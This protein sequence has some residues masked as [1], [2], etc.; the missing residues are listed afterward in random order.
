ML[1]VDTFE[2]PD[3]KARAF[4]T[5]PPAAKR[6]DSRPED[7]VRMRPTT[8]TDGECAAP[9]VRSLGARLHVALDNLFSQKKPGARQAVCCHHITNTQWTLLHLLADAGAAPLSMG[10][11]AKSTRLTPSG[12]TR[13][14]D[15]LVGRG[16]VERVMQEGDRR[17]CCLRLSAEGAALHETILKGCA[18]E[19]G[20]LLSAFSPD[21]REEIVR[22][23][24][25]LARAARET[26]P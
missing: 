20:A 12:V 7:S 13:C 21:E 10:E 2:L 17:V 1:M 11:I 19:D 3:K 9:S 5:T 22:A 15:P 16:L 25:K 24:E 8:R 4:L 6:I 14:A 26:P 18:V 23:V